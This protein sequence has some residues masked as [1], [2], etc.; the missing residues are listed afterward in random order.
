MSRA[1]APLTLRIGAIRVSGASGIEARRLADALPAA[2][3]A[4]LAPDAVRP[5]APTPV[6]TAAWRIADVVQ[7]RR[8]QR[9][10]GA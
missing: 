9:E 8:Q 2:L 10:P 4:A 1:P 7:S 5:R 6:E 3:A